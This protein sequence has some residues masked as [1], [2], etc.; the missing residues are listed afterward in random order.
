MG[1]S[2]IPVETRFHRAQTLQNFRGQIEMSRSRRDPILKNSCNSSG[3]FG[4][5]PRR[6]S[7]ESET[8]KNLLDVPLKIKGDTFDG[9]GW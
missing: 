2:I 1:N 5:S 4:V 7:Y 9:S 6:R 3:R 8:I